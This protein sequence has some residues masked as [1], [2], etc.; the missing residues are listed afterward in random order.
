MIDELNK[1]LMAAV[2]KGDLAEVQQL[3]EAGAE[4]NAANQ[5]GVVPLLVA[6]GLEALD[7]ARFLLSRGAYVNYTG[8]GEGSPLMLAAYDGKVEV[9]VLYLENGAD[10][11]LAM[12]S[13]GETA[14]HMAAVNGHTEAVRVLL[15]AG[16]DPNQ[17]TAADKHT[18]MFNGGPKLW[19]ETPLHF[20][21][22]YGDV[23]MIEAM[24]QAGADKSKPNAHGESPIAYAGRHKR[25]R[26]I[27][28]LLA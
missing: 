25:S 12:P 9:I 27:S 11:N 19:G 7:I 18:D 8:M 2:E 4:V 3:V 20:A 5:F 1:Q 26:D 17:P 23:A 21:A 14:L 6:S 13:G 28:Q 16:A 15:Q 10:P 24:L 22:A